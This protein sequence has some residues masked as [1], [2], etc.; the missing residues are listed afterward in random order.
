MDDAV[1]DQDLRTAENCS[2]EQ[3][4]HNVGLS[5][6]FSGSTHRCLQPLGQRIHVLFK[7][8]KA[9]G[10][11]NITVGDVG[12]AQHDVVFNRPLEEC[13]LRIDHKAPAAIDGMHV[14]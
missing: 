11:S 2:S 3:D 5:Q 9:Q 10:P 6:D 13:Q 8:C 14:N 12:T 7:F 4:P 1:K